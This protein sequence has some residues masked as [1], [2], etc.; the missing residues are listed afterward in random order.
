MRALERFWRLL[1][2]YERLTRDECA[3]LG[4]L[5]FAALQSIQ[6]RKPLIVEALRALAR[7]LRLDR[8]AAALRGR[9]DALLAAERANLSRA[10]RLLAE[11]ADERRQLDAARSRLRGLNAYAVSPVRPAGFV[12]HG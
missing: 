6:P 7:E 5:D 12:A 1:G 2:D 4:G 8:H 10:A 11:L 9:I 3:A